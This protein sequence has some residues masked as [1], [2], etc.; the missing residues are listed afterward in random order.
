KWAKGEPLFGYQSR[1]EPFVYISC[2]RSADGV[3]RTFDR[4]GIDP[5][6]CPFFGAADKPGLTTIRAVIN[7]ALK[8]HPEA[9]VLVVEGFAAMVPGG[10]TNDYTAVA[11][12]LKSLTRFCKQK[13]IT[14]I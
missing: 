4:L 11:K 13:R 10:Q 14:I 6:Q 2:D 8:L 7:Y 1:P 9:R 5:A 12:Y 3:L